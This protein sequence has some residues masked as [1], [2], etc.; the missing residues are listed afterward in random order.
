[1]RVTPEALYFQLGGLLVEMPNLVSGPITPE[2]NQWTKRA[3]ELI[4][5][6]GGLADSIQPLLA[7]LGGAT[8]GRNPPIAEQ[9]SP[10]PS[11]D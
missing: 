6:K 11:V 10:I 1:M 7:L 3:V 4:E 8:L 5:L 2:I 9:R